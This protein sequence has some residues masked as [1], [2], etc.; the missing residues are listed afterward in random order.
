MASNDSFNSG[1]LI[2]ERVDL[3]IGEKI[4][5]PLFC[6][7]IVDLINLYSLVHLSMISFIN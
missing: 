5:Q 4:S 1:E 6:K 3:A 7:S 2:S